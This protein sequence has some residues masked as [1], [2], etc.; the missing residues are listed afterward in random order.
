M[1]YYIKAYTL[2]ALR[3]LKCGGMPFHSKEMSI[4]EATLKENEKY[5]HNGIIRTAKAI[6]NGKCRLHWLRN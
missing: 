2:L 1:I 5:L 3:I 4:S 6:S